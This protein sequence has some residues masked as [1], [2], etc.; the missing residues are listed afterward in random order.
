MRPSGVTTSATAAPAG[1]AAGGTTRRSTTP[2]RRITSRSTGRATSQIVARQAVATHLL[3]RRL[4]LHVGKDHDA[5]QDVRG[6]RPSG[7]AHQA[8]HRPG[9]LAGVLDARQRFP[10]RRWPACGELDIM[11]N[12]GSAP[13]A[14][15]SA[16]HGP[17]YSGNTPFAH[18][19]HP[20]PAA[21]LTSDFHTY[22]VEWDA[23]PVRFSVDGATH[24]S[25]ARAELQ[26]LRQ[27]DPR[28]AVFRDPEPRGRRPFRRRSAIG[29]DLPG[30]DAGGLGAGL[31]EVGRV[32]EG[33]RRCASKFAAS[34]PV[35]GCRAGRRAFEHLRRKRRWRAEP[36][37][38]G[39]RR[40]SHS[41]PRTAKWHENRPFPP[42]DHA[43]RRNHTRQVDH[44]KMLEREPGTRY[45]AD[46]GDVGD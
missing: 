25:V 42:T 5:R 16:I 11:E 4:P 43:V 32:R 29:R 46:A 23:E 6:A 31:F 22:A 35:L 34:S 18:A 26:Q 33:R 3:L 44:M 14:T 38:A 41:P 21:A 45:L 39:G 15:S 19:Q 13:T 20:P 12:K 2:T 17:G 9:T 24:Y 8:S 10:R 36:S 28:P 30:D 37:S 1:T 40:S 7:G 27:L